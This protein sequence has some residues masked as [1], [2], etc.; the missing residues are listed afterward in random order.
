LLTRGGG[1]SR[2]ERGYRRR[3]VEKIRRGMEGRD[4]NVERQLSEAGDEENKGKE[5]GV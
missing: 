5:G 4:G 1:T 3:G 2:V